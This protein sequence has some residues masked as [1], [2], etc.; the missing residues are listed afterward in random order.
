MKDKISTKARDEMKQGLARRGELLFYTSVH[1][2]L[3]PRVA[4][5]S[6]HC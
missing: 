4:S 5:P 3:L 1:S 6:L 2:A